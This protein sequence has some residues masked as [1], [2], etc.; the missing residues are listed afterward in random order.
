VK[1]PQAALP[2]KKFLGFFA[3]RAQNDSRRIF[4]MGTNPTCAKL[5]S[6]GKTRCSVSVSDGKATIVD[7]L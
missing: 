7:L 2:R 5:P 1:N 6:A 3:L 4:L